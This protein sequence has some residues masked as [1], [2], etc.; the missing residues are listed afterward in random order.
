MPIPIYYDDTGYKNFYNFNIN[1]NQRY[2]D[3]NKNN[4]NQK[5]NNLNH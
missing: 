5:I 2:Y 3:N 1:Y 4:H